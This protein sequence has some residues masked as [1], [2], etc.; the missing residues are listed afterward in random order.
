VPRSVQHLFEF[1]RD[2]IDDIQFQVTVSF[3]QIYLEVINDLIDPA[4]LNLHIREDPRSGIFVESLSQQTV[5]S[6]QELLVLLQQAARTRSTGT[7]SMN[8]K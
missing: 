4:N 5:M 3:L 8:R 1:I 6:Q 7:T 2:H